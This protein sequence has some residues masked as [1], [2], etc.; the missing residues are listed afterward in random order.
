MVFSY[1]LVSDVCIGWITFAVAGVMQGSLLVMC[2]VWKIRQQKLGVDDF[3]HPVDQQS[4][5]PPGSEDDVPGLVVGED[6][7]SLAVQAALA[8]ALESA[9]ED[10]VRDLGITHVPEERLPE[11]AHDAHEVTPLLSK[12]PNKQEE[13]PKRWWWS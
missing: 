6:E 5:A 8:S 11:D 7:D 3:G 1:S 12:Q 2:V 9:V 4:I 13:R 10:D